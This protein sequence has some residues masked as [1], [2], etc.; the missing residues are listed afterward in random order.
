[1]NRFSFRVLMFMR[2]QIQCQMRILEAESKTLDEIYGLYEAG[3][4]TPEE[5]LAVIEDMWGDGN[6]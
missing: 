4:L 1:M 3:G 6:G 2:S 5:A